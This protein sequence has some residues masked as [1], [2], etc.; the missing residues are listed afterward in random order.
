MDS[1]KVTRLGDN[2]PLSPEDQKKF[3]LI[4][5]LLE[6]SIKA[7]DREWDKMEEEIWK[8]WKNE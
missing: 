8:E 4:V 1:S 6:Q 3:D 5:K 7:L 2:F